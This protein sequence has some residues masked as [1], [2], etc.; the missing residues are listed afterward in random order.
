M[1]FSADKKKDKERR[2]KAEKCLW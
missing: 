2:E 1:A